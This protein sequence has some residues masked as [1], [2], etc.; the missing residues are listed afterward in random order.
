VSYIKAQSLAW[1]EQY[2]AWKTVGG[3]DWTRLP[4]RTVE[5][6]CVLDRETAKETRN[7]ER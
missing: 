6:F 7:G 5:A 1:I 2:V 4:A 3:A